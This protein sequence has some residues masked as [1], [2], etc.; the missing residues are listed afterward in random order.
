MIVKHERQ[1]INGKFDERTIISINNNL[2][3][4]DG[5]MFFDKDINLHKQYDELMALADDISQLNLLWWES[6]AGDE[7]AR[8]EHSK[9]EKEVALKYNSL[10]PDKDWNKAGDYENCFWN[11][12]DKAIGKEL[13]L[14]SEIS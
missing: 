2:R 11:I 4:N 3:E 7:S 14:C 10:I 8:I 12:V 6:E 5:Q 1:F 13:E 9:L